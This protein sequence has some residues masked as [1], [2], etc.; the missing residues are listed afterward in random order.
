MGSGSWYRW[1]RKDTVESCQ[2]LDIN[3]WHRE[4]LLSPGQSFGWSWKDDQGNEKGSISVR[5]LSDAVE[6]FY[7][8]NPKSESPEE[9][10]YQVPLT[11]TSCNYGGGRPWF[12]CPGT[13]CGRRVVKL[14]LGS[15]YFLCRNCHNLAYESQREN[16][17]DRLFYKAQKIKKRLG[18]KP[19]LGYPFPKRPKGMHQQTYRRLQW[20]VEELEHASMLVMAERFG[21]LSGLDQSTGK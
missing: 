21:L 14:Y 16:R 10:H 9:I 4:G 19:G 7:I 6:L 1:N 12:V 15:K 8:I 2:N 11:R 20:E 5:V 3:R 13:G 18:G 17:S